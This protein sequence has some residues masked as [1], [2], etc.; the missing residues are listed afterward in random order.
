MNFLHR[1]EALNAQMCGGMH[2]SATECIFYGVLWR[3]KY[4][5]SSEERLLMKLRKMARSFSEI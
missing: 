5:N 1:S 2:K 4:Q 3:I